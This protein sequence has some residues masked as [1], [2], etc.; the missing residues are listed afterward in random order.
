MLRTLVKKEI[1]DLIRDPRIWIPV[2]IGFLVFP[3]LGLIQ[4]ISISTQ[5]SQGYAR[6]ISAQIAVL[7]NQGIARDF[8]E[9]L[10]ASMMIYNISYVD[11]EDAFPREADALI[12][13]NASSIESLAHGGRVETYIFYKT[14]L[15]SFS[16][17]QGISFRIERAII[18]ASRIY[19]AKMKNLTSILPTLIYPS[20]VY[21]VPYIQ[22]RDAVIASFDAN[23]IFISTFIPIMVPLI[24]LLISIFILQYSSVSMAVENE[25]KTLEVLLSMPIPR[26]DIV[27]AKLAASGFIGALSLAGFGLGLLLYTEMLTSSISSFKAL[28]PNITQG[29]APQ[30]IGVPPQ[31]IHKY[32]QGVKIQSTYDLISL[33]PQTIAVIVIYALEAI[34][35]AGT[36]G[37]V[38][39]G[40]S[41]D[42]RMATTIS[43]SITPALVI[44]WLATEF[45]DPSSLSAQV[46]LSNPLTGLPF[47][48][49]IAMLEGYSS[50]DIYIYLVISGLEAIAITIIAGNTLNIE[51]LE[52]LKKGLSIFRKAK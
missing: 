19:V 24:F 45:I 48:S 46:L 11:R 30:Y 52:R 27:L 50:P 6:Q 37:I 49:R 25:E 34:L 13:I 15:A 16:T 39:G 20:K 3:I 5:I 23:Q 8:L 42:V 14:E 44:L 31:I 38:I 32:L 35:I 4:N 7:D 17:G 2:L 47:Y 36:I 9:I 40:A 21:S 26:R 43:G 28:N 33:S 29:L 41:S 22:G 51:K 18:D 12:V 10:K 1:K